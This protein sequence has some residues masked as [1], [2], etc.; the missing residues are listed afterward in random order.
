M[1]PRAR[2]RPTSGSRSSG[3]TKAL[4][5]DQVGAAT[6][7]AWTA[8]GGDVLIVEA[9]AVRGKGNLQLTGQLGDVMKESAQAALTFAR[10][11]AERLGLAETTSRRTT[12]TSTSPRARSR[13]TARRPASRWRRR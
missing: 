8:V 6:G 10:S 9:R 12:S 7:L 2:P 13:R 5:T 1:T 11:R 4:R 3:G